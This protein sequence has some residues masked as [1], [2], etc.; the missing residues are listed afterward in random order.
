MGTPQIGNDKYSKNTFS[1]YEGDV[2]C[3]GS[4]IPVVKKYYDKVYGF[5]IPFNIRQMY[6]GTDRISGFLIGCENNPYYE[7]ES[8]DISRYKL[9]VYE[10]IDGIDETR[11]VY[12]TPLRCPET[13]AVNGLKWNS[14]YT[15]TFGH[16]ADGADL[17]I[18]QYTPLKISTSSPEVVLQYAWPDQ[19]SVKVTVKAGKYD[20]E[21]PENVRVK[22]GYDEYMCD[23]DGV[24]KISNLHPGLEY[25]I[26]AYADYEGTTI[27]SKHKSF[28]TKK[29]IANVR[30]SSED[31]T[32]TTA[33]L[34]GNVA[35][36]DAVIVE[37]GF[38]G[39][40][41][42][43]RLLVT[44][45]IPDTDYTYTFYVIT[46]KGIEETM[47]V[48][49][50][51][52]ELKLSML[53]PRC[54]SERCAIVAAE[55]NLPDTETTAGF[56]WKK[57]DAP[58][59]LK[60]SE[61]YAAIY[62]G[63]LEGYIKNLQPTYYNVRAF[64][65]NAAG[66]RTYTE[67]ITFDPT[68]FSFF[69]P[70]VH[71]YPVETVSN[72]EVMVRGYALAGSDPII[73]QGFQ[74][75]KAAGSAESHVKAPSADKI[76]TVK[77]T[78]QIMTATI[79]GLNPGTEYVLRS[80]VETAAGYTYGEEQPFTTTGSA[81]VDDIEEDVTAAEIVGYYDLTGRRYDTPQKGFNIVVYSDGSSRKEFV[82]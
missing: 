49:F 82:R 17:E 76:F 6:D 4:F 69:E 64:F 74:Y 38:K 72:N 66:K 27:S 25:G 32:P 30:V 43:D 35:E 80:F 10:G 78:G 29:L 60:P 56:Q 26:T 73:S 16:L 21:M 50:R 52:P 40:A 18:N 23:K 5:D 47:A 48:S 15:V 31:R 39:V 34:V 3:Q 41:T 13:V 12:S 8:V 51:T 67:W 54:V 28:S 65:E 57:Y 77:A 22:L 55:T 79:T 7:M 37:C 46:D 33:R 11:Q 63:Q 45:L 20:P 2:V 75:W 71:T 19:T 68:D 36:G 24:V 14:D 62:G 61:A 44:G 81:G 42:G 59:A 53:D 9:L 1:G 70:T 58:E